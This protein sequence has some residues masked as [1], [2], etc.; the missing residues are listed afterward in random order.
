MD[1]YLSL[2]IIFSLSLVSLAMSFQA[3]EYQQMIFELNPFHNIVSNVNNITSY[4]IPIVQFVFIVCTTKIMLLLF[5]KNV[6]V[7]HI[8]IYIGYGFAF[9]LLSVLFLHLILLCMIIK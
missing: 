4:L 7:L 2:S 9:I 3:N 8:S 6:S 5:D 1:K